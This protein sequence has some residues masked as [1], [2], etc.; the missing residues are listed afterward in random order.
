MKSDVCHASVFENLETLVEF[1]HM[2]SL[3]PQRLS[4]R[5]CMVFARLNF[6]RRPCKGASLTFLVEY[7]L[8]LWLS[9]IS[10]LSLNSDS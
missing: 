10:H 8:K 5:S 4:Q 9:I 1:E 6:A 3:T 2:T 7:N